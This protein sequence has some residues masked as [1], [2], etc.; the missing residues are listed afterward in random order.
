[1]ILPT[2]NGLNSTTNNINLSSRWINSEASGK[3]FGLFPTDINRTAT[4][5]LSSTDVCSSCNY[6]NRMDDDLVYFKNYSSDTIN[7]YN[8]DRNTTSTLDY[9]IIAKNYHIIACDE[10]YMYNRTY[11]MTAGDAND[12]WLYEI[13]GNESLYLYEANNVFNGLK[14]SVFCTYNKSNK[15]DYDNI[16]YYIW[17]VYKSDDGYLSVMS[18]Q[19]SSEWNTSSNKKL[20]S[21]IKLD[22]DEV[23]MNNPYYDHQSERVY[24]L[25]KKPSQKKYSLYVGVLLLDDML[26]SFDAFEIVTINTPFYSIIKDIAITTCFQLDNTYTGFILNVIS[27]GMKW[28]KICSNVE[29]STTIDLSNCRQYVIGNVY[30]LVFNYNRTENSSNN[31]YTLGGYLS[32]VGKDS[33]TT[34]TGS[35][36]LLYY[37]FYDYFNNDRM[38][39]VYCKKGDKIYTSTDKIFMLSYGVDN[40]YEKFINSEIVYLSIPPSAPIRAIYTTTKECIVC[41]EHDELYGVEFATPTK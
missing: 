19:D 7:I 30:N 33:L 16:G 5:N 38:L 11:I 39:W 6:S 9:S 34:P 18:P 13:N 22:S 25:T 2:L 35:S 21:K 1:M 17:A 4:I 15:T 24:I 31:Y 32:I 37:L 20:K 10:F 27:N 36:Q 40:H 12:L 28:I 26:S 23:I 41:I 14:G 3:D 29:S 8:V